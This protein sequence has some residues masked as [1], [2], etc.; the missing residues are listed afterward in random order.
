MIAVLLLSV[1]NVS[2]QEQAPSSE[3]KGAFIIFSN[4]AALICHTFIHLSKFMAICRVACSW[5]LYTA[6]D[7]F[8]HLQ[9][10]RQ[11]DAGLLPPCAHLLQRAAHFHVYNRAAVMLSLR[12][13]AYGVVRLSTPPAVYAG[14]R[15]AFEQWS[16]A[17]LCQGQGGQDYASAISIMVEELDRR[18]LAVVSYGSLINNQFWF[19]SIL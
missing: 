5:R 2:K 3:A 6:F 7:M 10:S 12:L 11:T 9:C 14:T 19:N 15:R 13:S 17:E 8:M 4:S 18:C 16:S 1:P